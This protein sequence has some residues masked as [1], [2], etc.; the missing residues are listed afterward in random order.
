VLGGHA[1]HR[2]KLN[3]PLLPADPQVG[4]W[5]KALVFVA[6]EHLG[7]ADDARCAGVVIRAAAAGLQVL[8]LVDIE[9]RITALEAKAGVGT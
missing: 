7:Q 4:D 6:N 5:V 9:R 1:A 8:E 2:R 3:A